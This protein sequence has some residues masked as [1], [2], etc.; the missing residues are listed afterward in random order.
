MAVGDDV[1]IADLY[2][3]FLIEEASKD[4][5]GTLIVLPDSRAYLSSTQRLSAW[6]TDIDEKHPGRKRG[7]WPSPEGRIQWESKEGGRRISFGLLP[8]GAAREPR[9]STGVRSNIPVASG[10]T[11]IATE[12]SEAPSPS[13]ALHVEAP[14]SLHPARKKRS[15]SGNQRSGKRAAT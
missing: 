5:K 12:A 8:S 11:G 6:R 7:R 13:A 9:V 14:S 2:V 15:A 10:V 3:K 1:V 4:W